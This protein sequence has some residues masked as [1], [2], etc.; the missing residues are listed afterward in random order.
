[1][2][3]YFNQMISLIEEETGM[4]IDKIRSTSPS[5]IISE[6]EKKK[7][8]L[9]EPTSMHPVI[10]RGSVLRD[11]YTAEELD[12]EVDKALESLSK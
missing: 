4:G 2:T 7:G 3:S 6:L 12:K 11:F 1:M 5:A 10:G 8:E 9:F